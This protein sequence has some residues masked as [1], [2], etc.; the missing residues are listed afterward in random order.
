MTDLFPI[1]TAEMVAEA[2]REV[3][4]RRRVY[5]RQVT[6]GNMKQADADRKIATMELIAAFIKRDGAAPDE[7][8]PAPAGAGVPLARSSTLIGEVAEEVALRVSDAG[9]AVDV[10]GCQVSAWCLI[11]AKVPKEGTIEERAT[12]VVA[13][14]RRAYRNVD[15]KAK[16]EARRARE[17]KGRKR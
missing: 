3:R 10:I 11:H 12:A 16:E 9:L 1:D 4:Q 17:S 13:E 5:A 14:L 7:G 2:E 8:V 6:L 15:L